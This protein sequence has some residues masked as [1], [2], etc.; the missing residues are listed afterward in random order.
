MIGP[1][2][3]KII[4]AGRKHQRQA[5]GDLATARQARDEMRGIIDRSKPP[6]ESGAEFPGFNSDR[7][8]GLIG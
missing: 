7:E 8:I 1:I 4:A 5:V 6:S 2:A 3:R